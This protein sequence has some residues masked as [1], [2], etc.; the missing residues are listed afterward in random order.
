MLKNPLV[1]VSRAYDIGWNSGHGIACHCVPKIGDAIDRTIDWIGLGRFVTEE[2]AKDY[3][4]ILCHAG[5]LNS[6]EY[7]PFDMIAKEFNESEDQEE[8][9]EAYEN[10]VRDSIANDLSKYDLEDYK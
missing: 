10:G 5:E 9:W 4:E 2:N 3:H 8:F 1:N 6:R 7:S